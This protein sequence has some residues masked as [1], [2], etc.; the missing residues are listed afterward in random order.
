MPNNNLLDS[1]GTAW[2]DSISDFG[3]SDSSA[4][5]S[6]SYVLV[7]ANLFHSLVEGESS[8][9]AT[10]SDH[11]TPM[12]PPAA[13]ANSLEVVVSLT[14]HGLQF[15]MTEHGNAF[16]QCSLIKVSLSLDSTPS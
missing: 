2:N 13:P 1:P 7:P 11:I 12:D 9:M 16:H 10:S 15:A 14:Q 6:D 3:S 5:V 8:D 4:T